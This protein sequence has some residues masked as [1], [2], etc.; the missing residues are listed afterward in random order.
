MPGFALGDGAGVD[1][2][3]AV[4]YADAH[5]VHRPR[6]R[7][8]DDVPVKSLADRWVETT[9][10]AIPEM[11]DKNLAA[12]TEPFAKGHARP[13]AVFRFDDDVRPLLNDAVS[14]TP[15]KNEAP[16]GD[17]MRNAVATVNA[18]LKQLAGS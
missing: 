10:E 5:G 1:Y 13:N 4:F 7:T 11:A 2:R 18:K 15:G 17:T 9:K 6:R 12:F 14:K 16:L 8:L 3:A